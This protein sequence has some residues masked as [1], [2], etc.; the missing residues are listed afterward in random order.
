TRRQDIES[1]MESF[2]EPMRTVDNFGGLRREHARLQQVREDLLQRSRPLED[3]IKELESSLVERYSHVDATAFGE[4]LKAHRRADESVQ[5][6]VALLDRLQ[7]ERVQREER[8]A[9]L[10]A[11]S[12]KNPDGDLEA[13]LL[14]SQL[15]W[16]P[17]RDA[18]DSMRH[19]LLQMI[20][21]RLD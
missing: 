10:S 20:S 17:N 18:A 11:R 4:L 2:P 3:Q 5:K 15:E 19:G 14:R 16:L 6:V 13:G 9:E 7:S 21:N 1:R 12:D 8:L